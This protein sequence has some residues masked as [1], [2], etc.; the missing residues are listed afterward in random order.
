MYGK[1]C[2]IFLIIS[3]LYSVVGAQSEVNSQ[4]DSL[5][6]WKDSLSVSVQNPAL[7]DTFST[8]SVKND[9]AEM[10]S[11]SP[12]AI[13]EK[14]KYDAQDSIRFDLKRR[15]AYLFNKAV[16]HYEDMTLEADYIEID[17]QKNEL[18]ASGVADSVGNI[19]G[20]PIFK[21]GEYSFRT[22]EI[23]YNFSTKKGKIW[24]VI[25]S[26]GE[27]YIHGEQVKKL[28]DNTSFI[29]KGKYTT[30]ELDH[31]HFEISF[32]KAKVIPDDKIITG[33]AYLSFAGIPT[34]LAI[35]FGYFPIQK[36]R[37]SGVIMPTIGESSN[38]G[39]YF[40][41]FGFYWGINDNIDL[42]LAG[43]IYT[44]GSWAAKLRSNY[45]FRYKCKGNINV[46]F[47]QNFFG[48]KGTPSRYNTNDFKIYWDHQQDAKSHPTTRFSAHVDV[49]SRSFNTYNPS[50]VSDYLS[51]QYTSKLNFSTSAGGVFFLDATAS[52]SQSTLTGVVDLLLPDISMSVNQ[53]YP[54]R[55]K[56]KTGALKWYDNISLKWSS[57]LTNKIQTYDSLM[58]R[59]KTWE[60][61][62]IGM[63][64]VIPLT[65]PIKI[66]KSINWNT[67]INFTEKWYLQRFEKDIQYEQ[68]T[69]TL[70]QR[71]IVNDIFKRDF[72]ALHELDI[73]TSLTTKIYVMYQFK[74][75]GLKAIRHVITPNLSFSYSPNLNGSSF[76]T[77]Q[78][79]VTG[80]TVE[81][82]YFANSIYGGTAN[83]SSAIA[84]LSFGN[85]LE[86]KVKSKRDTI[87]GT[88]K[89]AI[90]DNVNISTYYNFMA[91]SLK[92]APLTIS[93]RSTLFKQLY[94][95]F[96]LSFDPYCYG[97]NGQRIN[98]TEL[99]KNKRLY[100]FSASDVSIGLNFTLSQDL[101]TGKQKN[102][103]VSE[104]PNADNNV[105]T[106]NSLGMPTR[107]PDFSNPWSITINYTFAYSVNDNPYYYVNPV[108]YNIGSAN[109]SDKYTDN[110]IQTLNISGDVNI[111]KKWKIGFTTGYDF[112]QKDLSYTS[113]DIYRD[114]HC[115]EM[116]F[117][118][119]PFGM[120][121]GWS[122]TINVKA[123]VLQD[124]KYNMKRDFRDNF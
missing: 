81:Y 2:F 39:F 26:E 22:Q 75:G 69:S 88:K 37:K 87:T 18:Y 97:E 92:W 123:S 117:N 67:C 17:F 100:R 103:S 65:I 55:K 63:K 25:T 53:F 30:C 51:N 85:N 28:D 90:F 122:F 29:K 73:S 44:R 42:L 74:K 31:P 114:L 104:V 15:K 86:I 14:V 83:R 58:F 7:I 89:I 3:I 41:N 108:Y 13:R 57:Q 33:P 71:A 72:Y 80:E 5:I 116:R 11:M 6:K 24:N 50:S 84:K 62:Q 109:A 111:T 113:L 79:M 121:K 56:N 70:E 96:S 91:D 118:W 107:R 9:S 36:E 8:D 19:H 40:E 60:E 66:A 43:D 120:R 35:P 82:S 10:K 93:G 46:S 49:V 77:Y 27:G 110:I 21:Q 78:N 98:V 16:V 99:K 124:L 52:Y 34:F 105:F 119:I 1:K 32:T 45:V 106:E 38:R 4:Q 112:T 101:F 47:A 59:P 20:A 61:S 48:E 12:N 54:F 94:I 115:W 23:T 102:K 68:D 64:H 95:T 76:G